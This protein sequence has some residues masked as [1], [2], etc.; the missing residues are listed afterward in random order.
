MF[1]YHFVECV[2]L[3]SK[4]GHSG[5]IGSDPL[6][7]FNHPLVIVVLLEGPLDVVDLFVDLLALLD[8]VVQLFALLVQRAVGA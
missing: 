3:F 5:A 6:L 7:S 4:L 1:F 2:V 8:L